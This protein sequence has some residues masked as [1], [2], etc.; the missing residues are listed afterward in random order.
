LLAPCGHR[1]DRFH[2]LRQIGKGI[3]DGEPVSGARVLFRSNKTGKSARGLTDREG[4]YELSSLTPGDGLHPGK[5][6]VT[7]TQ[8]V[9]GE[10]VAVETFNVKYRS[11]TQELIFDV[12]DGQANTI[13]MQ[14]DPP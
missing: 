12:A 6:Y 1:S 7:F 13:D 11:P 8:N 4:Y 2:G 9:G 14:L 5:Y 10:M 3:G